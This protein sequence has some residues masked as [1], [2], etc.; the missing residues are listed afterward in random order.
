[1][2]FL[3][4]R[5]PVS[6]WT[7][8]LWMMLAMPATLLLWRLSRGQRGKQVS[9]LVFGLALIFCYGGS[10]LFHAV[11][12]PPS[13]VQ[14]FETLDQIG[15][16]LLIA[17]SYTPAAVV[18]L[19]DR[20]KWGVLG[21]SWLLAGIGISWCLLTRE[22]PPWLS[23]ALYLAMGW[24]AILC[25]FE[26]ARMVSHRA[27][28]PVVLGGVFYSVGAV[29][30]RLHWPV[31]VPNVFEA[32]EAFHLFVMA[33]SMAHFWFMLQVVV[34]FERALVLPMPADLAET[35]EFAGVAVAERVG[36]SG[37]MPPFGSWHF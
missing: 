31:L 28:M 22:L 34:P 4:F 29:L 30:N 15:I 21:T 11:Q 36:G 24:G 13:Q 7:H 3:S 17:G 26:L 10:T 18:L 5:E 12:L 37:K 16:F 9:L 8:G 32:H 19:Q 27:M 20:W 23:T 2:E 1:M 35:G 33:G 6:A 25:Y 14:S